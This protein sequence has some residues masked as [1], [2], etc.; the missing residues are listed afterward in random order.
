M[1]ANLLFRIDEQGLIEHVYFLNCHEEDLSTPH[2]IYSILD[3]SSSD[4]LQNALSKREETVLYDLKMNDTLFFAII[5]PIGNQYLFFATDMT[6]HQEIIM[7]F[8]NILKS[9][10]DHYVEPSGH[11]NNESRFYFES[12]QKLNNDLINKSR[13]VE[14]LNRKLNHANTILN[15][16]LIKDPLTGLTSR[17]QYTDEMN[18]LT[19]TSPGQKGLF[20]FI[21][22]DDF[23]KVN[24]T[25]GH[26]TGDVYLKTF[27]ERLK[28]LPFDHSITMRIAGDEF[29]VFIGRLDSVDESF[30]KEVWAEIKRT[31]IK[32][33]PIKDREHP[34]SLSL[35]MAVYNEDTDNIH[36]LIDY[37]DF[38][39]YQAKQKKGSSYHSFEE[40][41]F[42]Q[43]KP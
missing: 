15:N 24:D 20:C 21:D 23:K 31:V 41:K 4:A 29:G 5:L 7:L 26:A 18:Q 33:I 42:A 28:A 10:A 6:P 43:H 27:A 2:S 22:I 32:P 34:V 30:K 1:T 25:Y 14:R 11:K 13:E 38:A 40:S 17:Y 39:M 12:I 35:G 36:A 16:R 19:K 3:H 8:K 9:L 37:A